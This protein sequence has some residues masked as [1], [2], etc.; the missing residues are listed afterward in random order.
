MPAAGTKVTVGIRTDPEAEVAGLD[1][2]HGDPPRPWIQ[3]SQ[4]RERLGPDAARAVRVAAGVGDPEVIGRDHRVTPPRG[5]LAPQGV[6]RREVGHGPGGQALG[7]EERHEPVEGGVFLLQG[8]SG[9]LRV[10][11]QA[12]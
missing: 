6:G 10:P 3:P 2:Q 12:A 9:G 4:Q 7:L 8:G 11:H 5:E 1:P